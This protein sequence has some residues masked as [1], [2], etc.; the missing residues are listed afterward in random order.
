MP[1][2]KTMEKPKYYSRFRKLKTT[3]T[4]TTPKSLAPE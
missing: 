3:E 2:E 1:T 4:N